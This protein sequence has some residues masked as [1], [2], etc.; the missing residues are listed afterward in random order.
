MPTNVTPQYQK[1]E[2]EYLE[3]EGLAEKLK[4]LQK[5]LSLAPTHKGGEKLRKDIKQR[6]ARYKRLLEKER[7]ASK[8]KSGGLSI[9]KEGAAQVVLL[10]KTNSG[11][12]FL[13]SKL[14]NANPLVADY[15]F[16]TKKPEMG[17][18]IYKGI[19]IQIIEIPAITKDFIE[20]EKG[21]MFMGI[22]RG[23]DLIVI[24]IGNKEDEIFIKNELENAG[25]TKK[26]IV[27]KRGEDIEEIKERIWDNLDFIYVYTKSPGKEKDHPPLAL[28]KG[29]IIKDLAMHVHKDFIKKFDFARVWGKSAKHDGMKCGLKHALE[30]G[31]V[32]ELHTK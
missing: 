26:S 29:S 9:K 1:A 8:R 13:L 18:M 14:T 12:S 31:D 24:L 27:V 11:K 22:V 4:C 7:Q 17:T 32:I 5:M 6:I 3:A 21:P 23:S 15:E 2:K 20:R 19:P 16:T 30:S 10:G 28:K 25:V